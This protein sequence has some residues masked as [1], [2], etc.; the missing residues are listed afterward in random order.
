MAD[1]TP[2]LAK[3]RPSIRTVT[4]WTILFMVLLRIAIGWHFFY[5]GAWKLMQDD[6]RA[7]GY[8]VASSG[9]FRPIFQAMVPDVNGL[10]A[11][12]RENMYAR[13]DRRQRRAL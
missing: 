11:L 9:P 6:W 7:T 3:S 5:E 1:A 4:G 13:M 8:L 12:T 10:E 2:N